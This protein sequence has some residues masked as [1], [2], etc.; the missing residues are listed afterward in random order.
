MAMEDDYAEI[1]ESMF[2]DDDMALNDMPPVDTAAPAASS[3]P[4]DGRHFRVL[5][6]FSGFKRPWDLEWWI[7]T[8]AITSGLWVE[9]WSIDLAI[10]PEFDLTADRFTTLIMKAISLGLFHMI[11]AAPPCNSW[12]MARW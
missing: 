8:M 9:I 3:P 1:E 7:A 12:S 4:R 10:S 5:H 2:R 6:L 11:M